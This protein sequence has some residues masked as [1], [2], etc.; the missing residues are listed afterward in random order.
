MS[1]ALRIVF[2]G[3]MYHVTSRGDRRESIFADEQDRISL[4]AIVEQDLERFD[5]QMLADCL[6]DTHDHF[7]LHTRSANLSSLMRHTQGR[8][9]AI[10]IDR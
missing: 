6:V 10:L 5:A 3:A 1:R 4:L 9:K 8:F 2:T 7:V